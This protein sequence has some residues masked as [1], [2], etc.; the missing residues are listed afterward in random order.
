MRRYLINNSLKKVISYSNES[1]RNLNKKLDF[2]VRN[3][4]YKNSSINEEQLGN[5]NPILIENSD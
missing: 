3:I 4:L 2:E 5:W 1:L